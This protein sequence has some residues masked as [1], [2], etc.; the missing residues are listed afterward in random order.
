MRFLYGVVAMLIVLC[1]AGTVFVFSGLY[2]VSAMEAH[3]DLENWAM[4]TTMHNSVEARAGD[5]EVP[6]DL[7][8]DERVRQ[9]AK[10]YDQLCAVCHLKPGQNDSLIRQG[11]NPQP[12]LLTEAGHWSAAEKFWIIKNGIKMTGMPAWGGTHEDEDLW[13]ITAF[14]QRLP[15]LSEQQ[16][17]AL[18]Q[19]AKSG[20]EQADDG[21]DHV[22][23]DMSGMSAGQAESGHHESG[24]MSD[25]YEDGKGHHDGAGESSGGDGHG[26]TDEAGGDDH[27]GDGASH[28]DA[29]GEKPQPKEDD[30]YADGHTH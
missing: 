4:H 23:A 28:G 18:V 5:I 7:M 30:H 3:S 25:H 12:P 11:L 22:H 14:L 9:G 20:G 16:Y 10:G 19:P 13:E 17:A 24:A 2:N 1:L 21:H 15:E 8:T 27:H 26:K 29:A 6:A